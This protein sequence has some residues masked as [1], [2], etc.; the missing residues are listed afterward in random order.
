M[1]NEENFPIS[2]RQRRLNKIAEF[3]RN[4]EAVTPQIVAA[5]RA[6]AIVITAMTE[7]R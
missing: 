5:H 4:A 7:V 6:S 2:P 1:N 3:R